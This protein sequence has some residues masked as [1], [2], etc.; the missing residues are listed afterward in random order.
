MGGPIGE[1]FIDINLSGAIQ[2]IMLGFI[3][4]F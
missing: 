4:G 1:L 3:G 2:M